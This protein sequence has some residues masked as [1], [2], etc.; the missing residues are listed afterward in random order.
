MKCLKL[1]IQQ[2]RPDKHI[3]FLRR[4]VTLLRRNKGQSHQIHQIKTGLNHNLRG[5]GT[6]QG[7]Q[8]GQQT[9]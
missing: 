9:Y 5:V 7:N 6:K 1:H 3:E 2:I 4:Y 8:T